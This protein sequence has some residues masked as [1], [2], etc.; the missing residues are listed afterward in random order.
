MNTEDYNQIEVDE[1]LSIIHIPKKEVLTVLTN[2]EDGS[3]IICWDASRT[4][5]K[6]SE[7]EPGVKAATMTTKYIW[8]QDE[9]KT[10][11]VM[12]TE[13]EHRLM[14]KIFGD[15]LFIMRFQ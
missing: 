6:V 11:F 14:V 13:Y 8:R 15:R 3:G 4:F 7:T 5:F 1:A 10:I 9:N 2:T 12:K